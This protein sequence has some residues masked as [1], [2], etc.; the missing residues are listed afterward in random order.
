MTELRFYAIPTVELLQWLARGSLKQNLLRA[1][2]L[3][4]WLKILYGDDSECFNL[5]NSF[6]FAEWQNTF[7]TH[8]PTDEQP[9]FHGIECNCGKTVSDWLKN[10]LEDEMQWRNSL[11][12]H[13]QFSDETINDTL[14]TRL[15]AV[16]R[17]SLQ[18]D[19]RI[20]V[21]LGWLNK[22]KTTYQKVNQFPK[23]SAQN[24]S[25][26]D[27]SALHPDLEITFKNFAEPLGGFNRFF[28]EI[29]Y[30][31]S[32]SNQDRLE[33]H[34]AQLKDLWQQIPTPPV[35]LIYDSA[36]LDKV[37]KC[38]VYPICL[39]YSRR[40][41]YL[42]AFGETPNQQGDYY[43]YRL[44]RIE[45]ITPLTW[46]DP[47]LPKQLLKSYPH[48]LPDTDLIQK[49]IDQVWGFDFYLP[50]QLMLLR[51]GRNFHDKYIKNT[52]RHDT[53]TEIDY[54]EAQELIKKST[55]N[56]EQKTI[57]NIL[58]L[59]SPD[60][61]Y[62]RVNYRDGDINVI[63]RLRAWRPNVEVLIPE[64]IRQQFR[65]EIIAETQFYFSS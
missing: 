28:L 33:D 42:C 37:V 26:S 14:E 58:K 54:D 60:D 20:L 24:N 63:H 65:Q 7:F 40:A 57:L 31:I 4:V 19:L 56:N 43:N 22:S 38:I 3:W 41:L 9:Q 59:R 51:F 52:F 49:E 44:D 5:S 50:S 18:D 25:Y 46:S 34:Q 35:E 16:T 12:Q 8:P 11:K 32:Q 23:F 36:K 27:F 29:D 48:Q 61:A 13:D 10:V 53:F 17:R 6:K 45:K 30:I 47:Q 21:E 1:I 62:Y 39:Y 15:F 64:Q 55:V 2:R